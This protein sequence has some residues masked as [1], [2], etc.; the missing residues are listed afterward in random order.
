[1]VKKIIQAEHGDTVGN[2]SNLWYTLDI[3]SDAQVCLVIFQKY[4]ANS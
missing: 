2:F 4:L 3:F 1:M